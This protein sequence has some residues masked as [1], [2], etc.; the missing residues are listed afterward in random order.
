MKSRNFNRV[1]LYRPTYLPQN[2]FLCF[3]AAITTNIKQ[4]TKL[5]KI[6]THYWCFSNING[7]KTFN[8][9]LC[10]RNK[11]RQHKSSTTNYFFTPLIPFRLING[12]KLAGSTDTCIWA[13]LSKFVV[14]YR[15]KLLFISFSISL[16]I[17]R[18]GIIT[19]QLHF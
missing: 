12:Y 14:Y 2:N 16:S 11:K 4:A 18:K 15:I 10:S 8:K 3:F 1:Y 13:C 7:N 6:I 17:A 5:G 9:I 19:K